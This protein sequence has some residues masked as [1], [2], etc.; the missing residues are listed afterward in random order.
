[1]ELNAKIYVAGHRGLVGSAIV[2]HLQRL[3]YSNLVLQTRQQLDLMDPQQVEKFFQMYKPDYVFDAAAKVGGIYSNNTYSA[4]FIYENTMIQTN[5]IHNS[6]KYGVK[7]FL[8]LGSVCIYPKFAPVPVQESSLLN[9]ALEPTN[10]PYA[11]AKIHGIKMCEA[12]YK[13]HGFKSVCIMPS[14]LYGPGDNFHDLNGHVIPAMMQK[15]Y[16]NKK[17]TVVLWG[18]GT[19]QREFLH[20]TDMASACVFLMQHYDTG[21][22]ELINAG[23][24]E[25]ISILE[26]SKL[27]SNISNFQG[28]IIW[29]NSKP[30]GTPNRPL[31][32][33]KIFKMGWQPKIPLQQ[34]LQETYKIFEKMQLTKGQ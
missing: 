30:N 26:L 25:N 33:S 5:L 27:L 34:G 15:F 3:G 9:G 4:E 22:A 13:Q 23:S 1:M 16:K 14:N 8:F 17:G 10:E 19:P 28:S 21:K 31:D 6:W 12:Y 20:S 32:N 2:G 7:K 29:D 11:V 18:D 24:G